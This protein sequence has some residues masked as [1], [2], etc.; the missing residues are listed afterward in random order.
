MSAAYQQ[1]EQQEAAFAP[2]REKF[3]ALQQYMGSESSMRLTHEQLESYVVERTREIARE[4]VQGHMDLRAV[5]EQPVAVTGSDGIA[6]KQRRWATRRLRL[7]VGDVTVQRLLYQATCVEGLA[8][9]DGALSLAQ[10]GFS[11]GVRR[12]VAEEAIRGSFE[13]VVERLG[14]TTGAHVAKRQAEQLVLTAAVD[15]E[16]FY[17]TRQWQPEGQEQL[18]VLTFDGAGII[19]R[20]E[21]LREQTRQKAQQDALQPSAWPERLKTGEKANRKRMAEVASVYSVEPYIRTADDIIGEMAS[22]R[23]SQ[24]EEP[25][26]RPRPVNK[27][28]WASV[29]REM[30]DVID[31]GFREALRRDPKQQRSWVVLVDGQT[32]QL[33][34]V[35]AAAKRHHA[36]ITVVCDFIHVMEYLW[37]AAH[38]FHQ[39][40]SNAAR[41]WVAERARLLLEGA[42]PSQ[43][44]AGMRR[45]ATRQRLGQRKA[46]DTCAK[47]L[48]KRR[49]FMQYGDALANG[50]PIASGAIEGAC[51]HLVRDRL[52]CCGARWNVNGAESI[53][54]LRALACSGDFDDYWAFHLRCEH[55]RNHAAFYADSIVPNPIP[56]SRLRRIK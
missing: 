51:R 34:A 48:K 23:L 32:Q 5:A 39:P 41:L 28:V 52:D 44:A 29:E 35:L 42:D 45:S 17:A 54:K 55:Q 11:M 38:C 37:K 26:K 20:T 19:M 43:V 3:F 31:E 56:T 25:S 49:N 24:P 4:V 46:V 15:F 13:Q 53:L 22:I 33:E 8:P 21:G 2:A 7:L 10:D 12:R 6:R 36:N 47:Y 16:E 50:I 9:Q 30:I 1:I 27:R 18:L 40:G 14:A